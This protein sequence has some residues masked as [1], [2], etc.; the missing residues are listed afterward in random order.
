MP[1]IQP[2][3]PLHS[4][5]TL[6]LACAAILLL[7]GGLYASILLH[8]HPAVPA[9][10]PERARELAAARLS[11]PLVLPLPAF[12]T[13][14]RGSPDNIAYRGL[15]S[16][17]IVGLKVV[18]T[19]RYPHQRAPYDRLELQL[20][21]AGWVAATAWTRRDDLSYLVPLARPEILNMDLGPG[22]DPSTGTAQYWIRWKWQP[23]ELGAR[24]VP[25]LYGAWRIPDSTF[26]AHATLTRTPGGWGVSSLTI[27]R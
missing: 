26:G 22:S 5:H 1:P 6:L 8:R 24:L 16:A 3:K 19:R 17:G 20:T 27:E 18:S 12:I 2:R 21:D 4:T 14:R 7:S 23:T 15:A 25:S 11:D 9:L 10:T 13:V